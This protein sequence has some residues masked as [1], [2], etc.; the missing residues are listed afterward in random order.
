VLPWLDLDIPSG[1]RVLLAGP[2]GAGKST[3][4]RALAG[5]LLT[6]DVGELSGEVLV[7]GMPAGARPGQAGLLL[8]DPADALVA[9]RVGRDVAFGPENVG[10]DR[11]AIWARV[12][13]ALAAVGFP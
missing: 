1:Q 5:V 11:S 7:G 8:Q 6:A 13:D 12:S 4:L 10:L 9:A 2:S 3:L